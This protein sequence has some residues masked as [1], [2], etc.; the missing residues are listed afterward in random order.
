MNEGFHKMKRPTIKDV[1]RLAGVSSASVSN[2]INNKSFVGDDIRKRV[3]KA[4]EDLHYKPNKIA[5]QLHYERKIREPFITVIGL[6]MPHFYTEGMKILAEAVKYQAGKR[7]VQVIEYFSDNDSNK[8]IDQISEIIARKVDAIICFPVDGQKIQKS[9]DECFRAN[10][11]FISLNRQAYGNVCAV[12]KSDDYQAGNDLALYSLFN[13]KRKKGKILHLEG[14]QNDF[15]SIQRGEGF[16]R[17]IQN[18]PNMEIVYRERCSWNVEKAREATYSALRKFPE[19][20]IIFSES[21]EMAEAALEVLQE[22]NKMFPVSHSEH[23]MILGV[24]GNRFVLKKIREGYF[25]A[26]SEQL[27]WEQGCKA[28]DLA[29]SALRKEENFRNFIQ[30]P[31]ILVCRRNIDHIKYHWADMTNSKSFK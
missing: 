16:L 21:D 29:V 6:S 26:T 12:I 5:Q 13:L 2:V 4:I 15:N 24:D 30:L 14:D 3:L 20:N 19:I 23:I 11:P 8:Q 18:W 27:L 28:I 9:V 7:G 25:D 10:L 31:T 17:V 1:A 22:E